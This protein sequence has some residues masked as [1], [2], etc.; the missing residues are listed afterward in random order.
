MIHETFVSTA[1]L[2]LP[3]A[4]AGFAFGLIYFAALR[5]TAVLFAAGSGWL[6]PSALTLGRIGT[7]TII[8]TLAARLGAT[9]LL[10]TF[11]GFLVARGIA[12]HAVRSVK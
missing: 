9:P 8:L 10:A 3:M 11:V 2:A 7:A 5:R 4:F 12:L 6:A 1:L